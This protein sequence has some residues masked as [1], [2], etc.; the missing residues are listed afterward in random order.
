MTTEQFL[1]IPENNKYLE[2]F[3]V[4]VPVDQFR[5]YDLRI[6]RWLEGFRHPSITTELH[7]NCGIRLEKSNIPVV[8]ATPDRAFSQARDLLVKRLTRD[9]KEKI[10]TEILPL[11]FISYYMESKTYDPTRFN[12]GYVWSK[13]ADHTQ[14]DIIIHPYPVPYTYTYS[15]DV[16]TVNK[17][18]KNLVEQ[19]IMLQFHRQN[20]YLNFDLS[21]VRPGVYGDN[22]LIRTSLDNIQD[23]SIREPGSRDREYR[24]N[25]TVSVHGWLVRPVTV[26]PTVL[27]VA[28][29]YCFLNE[30]NEFVDLET[31]EIIQPENIKAQE[32]Q[33]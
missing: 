29:N 5:L 9:Q 3:C 18:T 8:S 28:F 7:D 20:L 12:T 15:I 31:Q 11:P 25:F 10:K 4:A 13:F 21:P 24:V 33:L 26:V 27:K 2:D 1:S 30:Q 32:V 22:V 16:W 17:T 14:K 19:W 23:N 6:Q